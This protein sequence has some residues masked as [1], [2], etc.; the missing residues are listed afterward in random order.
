M[1]AE[2]RGEGRGSLGMPA[3]RRDPNNEVSLGG[4]IGRVHYWCQET[5]DYS[6]ID[7]LALAASSEEYGIMSDQLPLEHDALGSFSKRLAAAVFA[8]IPV[9]RHYATMVHSGEKDGRSLNVLIPSPSGDDKRCVCIWVDEVVT[10]SV[11]FGPSHTHFSPDD[12]G[13]SETIELCRAVLE[14]K[15]LIIQNVGGKYDGHSGWLDIRDPEAI[16]EELT[17][18]YSPGRAILKS[19]SGKV[20]REVGLADL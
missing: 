18:P 17:S 4:R 12:A 6:Q 14:D 10:P 15:L 20:D 5:Y 16:E 19:W 2:G 13:I 1:G 9:A 7:T 3:P 8:A 11:G